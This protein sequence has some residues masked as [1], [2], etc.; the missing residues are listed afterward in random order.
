MLITINPKIAFKHAIKLNF[1]TKLATAISN[2]GIIS[3]LNHNT[4]ALR[5]YARKGLTPELKDFVNRVERVP[6]IPRQDILAF[7]FFLKHQFLNIG[8]SQTLT[9][10]FKIEGIPFIQDTFLLTMHGRKYRH[11][12]YMNILENTHIANAFHRVPYKTI[13]KWSRILIAIDQHFDKDP[14]VPKQPAEAEAYDPYEP[15]RAKAIK[16][17]SSSPAEWRKKLRA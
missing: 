16:V 3:K 7:V 1:D 12:E 14:Y 6:R 2:S 13:E 11:L 10:Y 17:K 4:K 9:W 15:K 5:I 8:T